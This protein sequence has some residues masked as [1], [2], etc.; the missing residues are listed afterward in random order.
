MSFSYE[1]HHLIHMYVKR[2]IIGITAYIIKYLLQLHYLLK[3]KLYHLSL[4]M[5]ACSLIFFQDLF[6]MYYHAICIVIF[7]FVI[8]VIM[9]R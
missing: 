8:V 2:R 7:V 4:S 9:A 1:D 5:Q 3:I 6:I